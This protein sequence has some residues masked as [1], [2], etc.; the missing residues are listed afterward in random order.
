ML[1]VHP[2]SHWAL[3]EDHPALMTLNPGEATA[4]GLFDSART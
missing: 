3:C 4:L 1:K 2:N